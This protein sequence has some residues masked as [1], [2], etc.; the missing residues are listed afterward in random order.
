MAMSTEVLAIRGPSTTLDF[1]NSSVSTSASEVELENS[2]P[3]PNPS[4]GIN[5][6]DTKALDDLAD[7]PPL[8]FQTHD[9]IEDLDPTYPNYRATI[10]YYTFSPSGTLTPET[11]P[12]PVSR[13][14]V[15]LSLEYF[16][17]LRKHLV[18]NLSILATYPGTSLAAVHDT[19]TRRSSALTA[20]ERAQDE[21]AMHHIA[22]NENL[23][24]V[25]SDWGCHAFGLPDPLGAAADIRHDR[26]YFAH[27]FPTPIGKGIQ[28]EWAVKGKREVYGKLLGLVEGSMCVLQ[29]QLDDPGIWVSPQV[30]EKE[31]LER[32]AQE[33][34]ERLNREA[35]EQEDDKEGEYEQDEEVE[36][37]E[38]PQSTFSRVFDSLGG[39]AVS[40]FCFRF[41]VVRNAG[42]R[43]CAWLGEMLEQADAVALCRAGEGATEECGE[44]EDWGSQE[45]EIEDDDCGSQE[46]K[47]E[48]DD[49]RSQEYKIGDDDCH[50]S[51]TLD[52]HSSQPDSGWGD[53]QW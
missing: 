11:H 43:L 53:P 30:M 19:A 16:Y 27:S 29:G 50:G 36:W 24:A 12:K 2:S 42:S 46:Y 31:R 39:N 34:E 4:L 49:C 8:P 21:F 23:R 25:N 52:A 10:H 5:N 6:T 18:A 41:G 9:E 14:S 47:I 28:L 37:T 48:D 38:A 13:I 35:A 26:N 20:L 22:I 33:E 1:T 51:R 3:S 45:C 7:L 32:E 40:R 15:L 17:A 44:G